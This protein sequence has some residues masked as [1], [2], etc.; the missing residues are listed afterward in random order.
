M[1]PSHF[2]DIEAKI[3]HDLK[4]CLD[5]GRHWYS[6]SR[7]IGFRGDLITFSEGKINSNSRSSTMRMSIYYDT[8]KSVILESVE[9][10]IFSKSVKILIQIIISE[11][12]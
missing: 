7:K 4:I 12:I 9:I 2:V 8:F 1:G 6:L 11:N 3:I 10:K 5:E